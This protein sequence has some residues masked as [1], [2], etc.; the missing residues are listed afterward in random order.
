[1][2]IINNFT[3]VFKNFNFF[4]NYFKPYKTIKRIFCKCITKIFLN[5]T[6]FN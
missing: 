5:Q 1:M 4:K 3:I 2:N 6:I